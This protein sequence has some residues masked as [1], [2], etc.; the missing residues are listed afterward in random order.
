MISAPRLAGLIRGSSLIC[1][2]VSRWGGC[3]TSPTASQCAK[4][5]VLEPRKE[6]A[7]IH[8]K[9]LPS[10]GSIWPRTSFSC[11]ERRMM[12]QSC[13]AKSCRA[14]SFANSWRVSQHAGPRRHER[15][16]RFHR[17]GANLALVDALKLSN[18]P[19]PGIAVIGINDATETTD[20][21]CQPGFLRR[22]DIAVLQMAA[23][24]V[25]PT[26]PDAQSGA[27]CDAGLGRSVG[28]QPT[29]RP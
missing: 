9:S 27:G 11:V 18:R 14:Y 10:S 22:A 17:P 4:F 1:D 19:R 21:R 29:T 5:V 15:C 12:D 13:S 3:Q 2:I 23:G 25:R 20:Y 8:G 7:G 28:S 6:E 16:L 26:L 24:K